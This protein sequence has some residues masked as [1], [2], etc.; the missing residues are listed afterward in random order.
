MPFFNGIPFKR[1]K[2]SDELS[3][4][5]LSRGNLENLVRNTGLTGR[6]V[7]ECEILDQIL[8][9]VRG[10]LHRN[11]AR[12]LLRCARRQ[13]GLIDDVVDV[14]REDCIQNSCGRGF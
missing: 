7:F 8:C 14:G 10:T 4:G 13:L 9:V 6:V 5:E 2:F 12:T 1:Q 3:E 11:H